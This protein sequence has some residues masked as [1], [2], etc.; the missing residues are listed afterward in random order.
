MK[1]INRK[2][3]WDVYTHSRQI[4]SPR[5]W[6]EAR[7]AAYEDLA[8]DA[9]GIKETAISEIAKMSMRLS[10]IKLESFAVDLLV[11]FNK[12]GEREPLSMDFVLV[13]VL[14]KWAINSIWFIKGVGLLKDDHDSLI[15]NGYRSLGQSLCR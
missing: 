4:R 5:F 14:E 8:S 11:W 13:V 1:H 6:Q 12:F 3:M 10:R 2:D 15:A 7:E 9:H